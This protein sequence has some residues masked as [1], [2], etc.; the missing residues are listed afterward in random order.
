LRALIQK[1]FLVPRTITRLGFLSCWSSIKERSLY[2]PPDSVFPKDAWCFLPSYSEWTGFWV[3][4]I[5][6]G[7]ESC[8]RDGSPTP[9]LSSEVCIS[10]ACCRPGF[11]VRS[12]PVHGS[13]LPTLSRQCWQ[14]TTAALH[15]CVPGLPLL[16]MRK[17]MQTTE[18]PTR[19]HSHV[20]EDSEVIVQ[21]W[22][23]DE[24][25]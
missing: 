15:C 9:Q 4:R 21:R 19:A 12:Q 1:L 23:K 22:P 24:S 18:S 7:S 20:P 13:N 6:Q 11:I 17:R 2:L 10:S 3:R 25:I 16:Q 14:L 8:C 5:L